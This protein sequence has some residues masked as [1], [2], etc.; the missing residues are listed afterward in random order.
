M[1]SYETGLSHFF[2]LFS[3]YHSPT[4]Y[5]ASKIFIF[6]QIL[7]NFMFLCLLKKY[8][9]CHFS[10]VSGS[11][12]GDTYSIF[13]LLYRQS[14]WCILWCRLQLRQL[15]WQLTIMAIIKNMNYTSKFFIMESFKYIENTENVNYTPPILHITQFQ[16]FPPQY[17]ACFIHIPTYLPL[18]LNY[19]EANRRHHI[20][21]L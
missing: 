7:S 12:V 6:S 2:G 8:L 18:L 10:E 11:K 9:Y 16:Q 4:A 17:Q 20:I 1:L 14:F 21:S 19:F 5:T 13:N 15:T 3:P